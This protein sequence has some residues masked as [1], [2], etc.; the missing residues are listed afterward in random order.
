M[1][2][3]NREHARQILMEELRQA[4]GDD[5]VERAD[6]D[7]DR[8]L[9]DRPHPIRAALEQERLMLIV[10]GATIGVVG[11]IAALLFRSWI[12]LP[13]AIALH[14]IFTVVVVGNALRLASTEEKPSPTAEAALEEAGVKDPEGAFDELAKQARQP[15]W[16]PHRS[17]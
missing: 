10:V 8:V 12:F 7:V 6:I 3:E 4:V 11:V 14:A 2:K 17:S 1:A 5:Q 13:V 9:D 15:E 16:R